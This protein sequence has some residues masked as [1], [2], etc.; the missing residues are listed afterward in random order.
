MI[1]STAFIAVADET[2][3]GLTVHGWVRDINTNAGIGGATVTVTGPGVSL[4]GVTYSISEGLG[5]YQL[6]TAT[7][8]QAENDYTISVSAS[9]YESDSWDFT[10]LGQGDQAYDFYMT[11]EASPVPIADFSASPRSGLAP[12]TVDFSD[13][14]TGEG[15]EAWEWDFGDESTGDERYQ[16]NPTHTYTTPGTYTVSLTVWGN[17]GSDTETKEDY[18][19]VTEETTWPVA[20]FIGTPRS[21]TTPLTVQFTDMSTR[22]GMI[23]YWSWN[24]GDGGTSD[25]QS[26]SHTYTTAGTYTVSLTITW[27]GGDDTETKEAYITVSEATPTPVPPNTVLVAG[28][29]RH[30]GNPMAGALVTLTYSGASHAMASDAAGNFAFSGVPASTPFTLSASDGTHSSNT[31]TSAGIT[32]DSWGNILN[33]DY[34]GPTPVPPTPVPAT[35]TPITGN[36]DITTPTPTPTPVP[37]H[38][39][40]ATTNWWW[41]L[42]LLLIPL[43]GIVIYYFGFIRNK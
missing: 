7:G 25:E 38:T 34:E 36:G 42:L 10:F 33:I 31:I 29:V 35:P 39:E 8:F 9:G 5:Y 24:F 1:C 2:G 22:Q 30:N 4:S 13:K 20:A 40:Q 27:D 6:S 16:R 23:E 18:I 43:A 11:P 14:S 15:L 3:Q 32:T 17:G 21:G 41:I 28:Q 12:L 26:P 37:S 19:T